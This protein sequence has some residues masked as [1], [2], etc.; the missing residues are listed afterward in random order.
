MQAAQSSLT[1]GSRLVAMWA[2]VP[3]ARPVCLAQ[4]DASKA[5]VFHGLGLHHTL[6]QL[7][8]QEEFWGAHLLAP[9]PWA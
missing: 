6:C 3:A 1:A 7:K 8:M 2:E 9:G 4:E 5:Y